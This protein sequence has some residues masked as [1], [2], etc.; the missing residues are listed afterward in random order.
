MFTLCVDDFGVKSNALDDAHHLTNA[1]QKYFECSIDWEGQN[2]HVLT[3]DCNY[4]K[5]YIDI[6]MPI[7]IPIE[8]QK[9]QQ[10]PPVRAQDYPHT[11]NKTVYEKQIELATQQISVLKLNSANNNR[12]QSINGNLL[13][14]DCAVDPTMIPALR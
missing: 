2:Y 4:A 8:F 5:N 13:Y 14:Y 7:Y 1:I 12:V 6:S 3:L 11:C 10:K 9:L